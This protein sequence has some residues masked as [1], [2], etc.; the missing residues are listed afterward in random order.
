MSG[1]KCPG[2]AIHINHQPCA[3]KSTR[4]AKEYTWPMTDLV[5]AA[6]QSS[7]YAMEKGVETLEAKVFRDLSQ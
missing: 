1:C 2:K 7:T 5:R 4:L 6:W 3:G